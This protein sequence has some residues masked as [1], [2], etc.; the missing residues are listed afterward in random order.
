MIIDIDVL[1]GIWI[2]YPALIEY[3]IQF[4]TYMDFE[5]LSLINKNENEKDKKMNDNLFI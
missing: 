4:I 1:N 2:L 5:F 3:I